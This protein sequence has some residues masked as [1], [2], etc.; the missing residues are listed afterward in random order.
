MPASEIRRR[1][2]EKL[3]LLEIEGYRDRNPFDLSGGQIQ[4]V[5]LAGILAMEP[6]VL[7]LDE[8]TSQLDPQGSD[9]VFQVVEKLA[10]SG[11]TIFMAEHKV[12][13]LASYCD[14]M[15][16]KCLEWRHLYLP[17]S[18]AALG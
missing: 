5:A 4:R 16:W 9:E 1:V 2:E 15:I 12:E 11:I 17:G 13:K 7:V 10:H 14:K 3:R 6:D 8:P 18:A